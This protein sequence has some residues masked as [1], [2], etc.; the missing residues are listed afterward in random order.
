MTNF[1]E[2]NH[3]TYCV[4]SEKIIK[5]IILNFNEQKTVLLEKTLSYNNFY[6]YYFYKYN[7]TYT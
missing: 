3:I 7:T 2:K 1:E 6:K 4:I 5:C